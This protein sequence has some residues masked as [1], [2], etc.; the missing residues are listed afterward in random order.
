M[1]TDIVGFHSHP[2]CISLRLHAQ[3][4][5]RLSALWSDAKSNEV[6]V[7]CTPGIQSPGVGAAH[8]PLSPTAAR[9]FRLHGRLHDSVFLSFPFTVLVLFASTVG[10]LHE[11]FG[12]WAL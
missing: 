5:G 4:E 12:L 7:P 9:F 10:H 2:S 3:I 6:N 8:G 11:L 1:F